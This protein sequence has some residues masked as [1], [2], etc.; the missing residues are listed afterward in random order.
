M[1]YQFSRK[2]N[3]FHGR[4]LPEE[5]YLVGYALLFEVIESQSENE[6][7]LPDILAIATEKHQR[8]ITEDWTV[9][10]I[11]HKPKDDLK[12]HLVFALKYEALDLYI[13]KKFFELKG[14]EV[15]LRMF[16]EEPTSQ[17][18]RRA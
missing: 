9:F 13:L 18:T 2:V 4:S 6:I 1:G 16:E 7:P 5:G 8:Y 10:T 15:V 14:K 17:Y 11:R 3:V 12:S